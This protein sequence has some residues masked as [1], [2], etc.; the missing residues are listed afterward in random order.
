M[1]YI[2]SLIIAILIFLKKHFLYI[3]RV[4]VIKDDIHKRKISRQY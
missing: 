3:V 1:S 4:I 2:N